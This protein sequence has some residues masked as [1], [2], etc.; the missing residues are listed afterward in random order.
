MKKQILLFGLLLL[1]N[2]S[3][4]DKDY[5]TTLKQGS[6]KEDLYLWGERV[7]VDAEVDGDVV[8]AGGK[9][10][11]D[12]FVAGDLMAAGG[13]VEVNAMLAD[14]LRSAG[15]QLSICS[16]IS[17]DA[18]LAGGQISLCDKTVI[19]DNAWLAG[20]E[21][22]VDGRI[23]KNLTVRAGKISIAGEVLQDVDLEARTIEIL[24][25]A[26]IGG[27]LV[28][29]S[30]NAAAI[31]EGARIAGEIKQSA[32]DS[33]WT[34]D[35]PSWDTG[36]IVRAIL[37]FLVV[38]VLAVSLAALLLAAVFPDTR[39]TVAEIIRSQFLQCLGV[40]LLA[41]VLIPI[42]VV[43]AAVTVIGLPIAGILLL[44]YILLIIAGYF[45]IVLL[46]A[47]QFHRWIR[48]EHILTTF[49]N[50]LTVL[51]AVIVITCIS[52]IPLLGGLLM[53][54]AYL[55]GI[56]AVCLQVQKFRQTQVTPGP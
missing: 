49:W 2:H 10:T 28:Y 41:L 34:R 9:I 12:G 45:S 48:K 51:L 35:R 54:L 4:A 40:G 13:E 24:P 22:T 25:G 15:G 17:G 30:P 36:D 55:A 11:V 23:E 37:G 21:I 3:F 5:D 44:L 53:F 8:V 43:L 56:G 33:W 52:L 46:I 18:V 27:D 16:S 20:S 19:G 7:R 14:D 6:F 29:K 39:F 1:S 50:V 26:S 38:S 31:G 47:E 42:L 32:S